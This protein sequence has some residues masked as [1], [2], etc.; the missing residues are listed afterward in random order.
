MSSTEV[1]YS[2]EAK[3]KLAERLVILAGA[4]CLLLAACGGGGSGGAV[5]SSGANGQVSGG[6]SSSS[7]SGTGSSS[8]PVA[9]QYPLLD[10]SPALPYQEAFCAAQPD[11][12]TLPTDPRSLI[13]PG[14]NQGKYVNFNAY[15]ED[16]HRNIATKVP[17][18]CG[19]Y[20]AAKAAGQTYISGVG[21]RA[22]TS[23]SLYMTQDGYNDLWKVWGLSARPGNF[24]GQVQERWGLPAPN[25][26]NPYP[27]TGED[28]NQTHGGSG[29]LP[30]GFVQIV[31]AQGR[32]TGNIGL[33]CY[34]CHSGGL[35]QPS[36]GP[37]LGS[38]SGLGA[39]NADLNLIL[40]D[41]VAD[42][43]QSGAG[44]TIAVPP[45][46]LPVAL[47]SAR[48]AINASGISEILMTLMDL[49]K[50]TLSPLL[51]TD[52]IHA[53]EGDTKTASWWWGN[54]RSRKFYDGG[55]SMD[56]DRMDTFIIKALNILQPNKLEP[57]ESPDNDTEADQAVAYLNS[58]APPAYPYGYCTGANGSAGTGD[59]PACIDQPLA[60]QGAILFH[61][62]D[63]WAGGANSAIPH[64]PG[65]GSCA[66]CHGVYSPQFANN[67]DYLADPRAKDITGYIVPLNIIGTDP[68]RTAGFTSEDREA[69]SSSYI[70]Y[71]EGMAGY[72][73][74]AQQTAAQDLAF[75]TP[76]YKNFSGACEWEQQTVGYLTPTLRGVWA[77]APYLHNA[78]VPDVWSVLKPSDRPAV[79]ERLL[80]QGSG[81]EHGYDTSLQA[82]DFTRM[83]WK[84]NAVACDG[85]IPSLPCSTQAGQLIDLNQILTAIN[86]LLG[87]AVIYGNLGYPVMTR[88]EI[89]QR[90]IV[91]THD[92]AKGNAGHQFTQALSDSERTAIIEYLKT[93]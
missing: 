69:L 47:S 78:S 49:Q 25:Y 76:P 59:N 43:V 20:R 74:P 61:T 91:N 89:E 54:F 80:T 2:E 1:R 64:P 45:V 14:F 79:W 57:V 81:V 22:L 83:G 87:P 31:N 70:S 27:L 23:F 63:L 8:G 46:P 4:A 58:I 44:N 12:A 56:D 53:S 93:L 48:G 42:I 29:Q 34:V 55:L 11:S 9:Q 33:T 82:Y 86:K 17:Q 30:M 41:V 52:P 71:P 84:Y 28:P 88:T 16:C 18:T 24:D 37:G 3:M 50:M 40:S 36:D 38:I 35:G 68:A 7:G 39:H 65:N 67:P 13:Q 51:R 19:A 10:T 85:T 92:Y 60:E 75:N 6:G 72:I 5:G 77:S 90:K 66:S 62:M 21:S 32:Y 26:P 15:W 73:P